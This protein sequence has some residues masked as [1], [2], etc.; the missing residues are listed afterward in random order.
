MYTA[1]SVPVAEVY[2]ARL[3]P[4]RRRLAIVVEGMPPSPPNPDVEPR[5]LQIWADGAL[6]RSVDLTPH[7]AGVYTDGTRPPGRVF[8]AAAYY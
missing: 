5:I 4:S 3:S 7:V 1:S 2:V 8:T 6:E